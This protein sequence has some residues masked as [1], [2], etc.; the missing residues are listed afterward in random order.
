[1]ENERWEMEDFRYKMED[2]K[3]ANG[4]GPEDIKCEVGI[5]KMEDVKIEN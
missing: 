4:R 2:G 1:M 3:M 5:W